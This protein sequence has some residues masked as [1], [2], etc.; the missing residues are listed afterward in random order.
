MAQSPK[1]ISRFMSLVLRHDPAAAG[2]VLDA[3]GWVRVTDLIGGLARAGFTVDVALLRSIVAE[4]DKQ[5]FA[6]SEDGSRIRANQGHSVDVDLGLAPSAPPERL[7]HGTARDNLESIRS[8]GLR[9]GARNHVHLSVDPETAARVGR[10]HG[11]PVVLVVAAG[12]M[13]AAGH[14]FWRSANGVWLTREVPA[15]FIE[16][17][18]DN[19]RSP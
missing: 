13:A 2:L 19:E 7:Y 18:A 11:E 6:L 5:R 17:P 10:R 9:P 3:N 16:L 1:Q 12:A 8:A 15:G 4:S 14:T